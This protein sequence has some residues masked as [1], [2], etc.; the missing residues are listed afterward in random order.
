MLHTTATALED[1]E[2]GDL[3]RQHFAD[4]A[5]AVTLLHNVVPGAV[6]RFLK[7][8]GLLVREDV[9][10]EISQ[11]IEEIWHSQSDQ[12]PRADESALGQRR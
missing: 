7:E 4:Y 2:V 1:Q 8:E 6:I 5:Q 10:P 9:L 11:T 3:A 12:A